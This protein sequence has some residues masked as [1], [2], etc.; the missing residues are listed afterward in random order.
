MVMQRLT[1][2]SRMREGVQYRS[3]LIPR[4]VQ[5]VGWQ[6]A[7]SLLLHSGVV[8]VRTLQVP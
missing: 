6:G 5:G 7:E 4:L 3:A 1:Q 8:A 2:H